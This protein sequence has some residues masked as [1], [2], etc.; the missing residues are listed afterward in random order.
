MP[1]TKNRSGR[2]PKFEVYD[3]AEVVNKSI[4]TVSCFLDSPDI[5]L[6]DKAEVAAR[7]ALKRVPDQIAMAVAVQLTAEER[8]NMLLEFKQAVL[9]HE[10]QKQLEEPK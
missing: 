2:K 1:G 5:P 3:I 10:T 6:R 4:H 7:F 8:N 9:D